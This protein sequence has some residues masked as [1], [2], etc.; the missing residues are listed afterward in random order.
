MKIDVIGAG[1]T[2]LGGGFPR[3]GHEVK[4]GT[5]ELARRRVRP[6]SRSGPLH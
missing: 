5:C 2:T 4:L 6:P 3:R 1:A